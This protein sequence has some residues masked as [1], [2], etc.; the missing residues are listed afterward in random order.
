MAASLAARA[1]TK[2]ALRAR[3]RHARSQAMRVVAA[4]VAAAAARTRE[5]LM[6]AAR[7]SLPGV[8]SR[9]VEKASKPSLKMASLHRARGS[10]GMSSTIP[11][12]YAWRDEAGPARIEMQANGHAS[13]Q[14]LGAHLPIFWPRPACSVAEIEMSP[15]KH[16]EHPRRGLITSI[17]AEKA[18]RLQITAGEHGDTG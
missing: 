1:S 13:N 15:K 3:W 14:L 17:M 18:W 16:G 10:A 2:S 7:P 5:A 6:R 12:A 4:S 11:V 8:A 9:V